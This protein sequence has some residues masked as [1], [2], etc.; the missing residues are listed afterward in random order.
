GER[1]W[2]RAGT[3]RLG[4]PPLPQGGGRWRGCRRAA[5]GDAD[6]RHGEGAG[7]G[8]HARGAQRRLGAG[9]PRRGTRGVRVLV[10]VMPGPGTQPFVVTPPRRIRKIG[11]TASAE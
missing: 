9:G 7:A 8:G 1:P 10:A 5:V 4:R 11:T 3:P 2:Y 6:D